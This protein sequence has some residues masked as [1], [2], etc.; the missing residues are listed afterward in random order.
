MKTK[1]ILKLA[2]VCAAIVTA[3]MAQIHA[4]TTNL[5]QD[6]S[7]T[8]T[9][10]EQ[11]PTNV[12]GTTTTI[13][14]KKIKVTTKD[15]IAAIGSATTNSF[16]SKA[17]LVL[18]R[19]ASSIT[20]VSFYEI[21]DGTNPPVDITG[22]FS[23]SQ[24][25]TVYGSSYDSATGIDTGV[26]YSVLHILLANASLTAGLDLKGFA[27]TTHASIKDKADHTVIGVDTIEADVSGTGVD[28]NGVSAVVNGSVSILGKT[29]KIE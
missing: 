6:I 5:V 4:A 12:S 14:V 18:V 15:V 8:L 22:F 7:F 26:N 2:A 27:T 10:Y 23:R 24:S 1:N 28:I 17:K 16:S 25:D 21:R 9:F 3:G 29:L 20:N 13:A 11:G 19:D